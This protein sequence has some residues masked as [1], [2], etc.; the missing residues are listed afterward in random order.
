VP[1]RRPAPERIPVDVARRIALAGQGFAEPR[2]PGRVDV[3]HL[4][5]AIARAG[6]LQ[7]DSVNVLCRSH[8]LPLFARLGPYARTLLDRMAWGGRDRELF[9]YWG[10][11]ASLLPLGA[12]PLLR[13]RMRA[14]AGW[15]WDDWASRRTRTGVP[16][17][18]R[19]S[20]DPAIQAPWAVVEGMTRLAA[21]RPGLVEAVLALVAE[22]GPV[23]AE[24]AA[25]LRLMAGWLELGR[26]AVE[27]SGDLAP[28]LSGAVD[29]GR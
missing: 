15:S 18:W 17:D 27:G 4:R 11:A 23:A 12:L 20:W 14:A 24:L 5:R 28:A 1:V 7:I 25:E 26:V 10:H 16:S 22:R 13:W 9:E 6:L 2:P 21:E 8:Y 29:T 19:T 3:R